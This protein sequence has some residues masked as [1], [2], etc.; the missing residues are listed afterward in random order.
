M[1]PARPPPRRAW[2]SPKGRS[3]SS[4]TTITRSSGTFSEPRAGPAE[5]PDSFM[6]VCGSSSATRGPPGRGPPFGERAA[7][8]LARPSAGPSAAPARA[9]PRSRRCGGCART[10]A[11]VAEPDDEDA[12]AL[13][14]ALAAAAE[15][16]Q[17]YYSPVGVAAESPLV[18]LGALALGPRLLADQL[19]LLLDL[20]LDS[21]STRGGERVTIVTSSGSSAT[22]VTPSGAVTAE[23]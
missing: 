3:I 17:G 13:L 19:G 11:R 20:G 23:S 14:A 15:Q 21:S 12:V 9:R 10:R 2:T 5:V 7:E 4:W 18:A 16:R 8:L 6:K 1:W 22:K